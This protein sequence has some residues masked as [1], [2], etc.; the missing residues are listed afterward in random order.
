M[1]REGREGPSKQRSAEHG[2]EIE[3]PEGGSREEW[4]SGRR[5]KDGASLVAKL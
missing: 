4:D 5:C 1:C 2:E 3:A